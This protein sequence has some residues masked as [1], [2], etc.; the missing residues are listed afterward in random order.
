MEGRRE[1]EAER[2][3]RNHKMK[4]LVYLGGGRRRRRSLLPAV[5]GEGLCAL[6]PSHHTYLTASHP[7]ELLAKH[8]NLL[9]F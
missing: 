2:G 1:R 8:E 3:R 9:Y 7:S 6:L 5:T 4:R